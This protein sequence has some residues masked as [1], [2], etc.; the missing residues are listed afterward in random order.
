M[1]S[2]N[3]SNKSNGYNH[4]WFWT[5]LRANNAAK[6]YFKKY[7]GV[8][9]SQYEQ[10]IYSQDYYPIAPPDTD[11]LLEYLEFLQKR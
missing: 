8:D 7:Y 10:D 2:A 9:W 6:K 11:V 4:S 5:E 1:K 3:N